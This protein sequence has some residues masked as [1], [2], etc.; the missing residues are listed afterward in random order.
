MVKKITIIK[1]TDKKLLVSY[2]RERFGILSKQYGDFDL[3]D[4]GKVDEYFLSAAGKAT[5]SN[6]KRGAGGLV[7]T[8]QVVTALDAL[9]KKRA[10]R[11]ITQENILRK[12]KLVMT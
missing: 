12:Q 1:Q 2:W 10:K 4:L 11:E 3:R 8:M 7:P 6:V 9:I 5:L